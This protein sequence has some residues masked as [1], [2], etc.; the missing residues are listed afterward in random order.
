MG[1]TREKEE[2]KKRILIVAGSQVFARMFAQLLA[3]YGYEVTTA[4]NGKEGMVRYRSTLPDLVI[5]NLPIGKK[6]GLQGF[7]EL[8]R[9]FAGT[10][11][12]ALT[13][14]DTPGVLRVPSVARRYGVRCAFLRPFRTEEVLEAIEGELRPIRT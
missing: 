13:G 5:V 11:L 10:R 8:Q 3:Q 1:Q 2:G 4:N 6:D 7:S 14:K 9:T 12:I